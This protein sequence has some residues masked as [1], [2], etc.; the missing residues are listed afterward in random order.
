MAAGAER[1]AAADAAIALAPAGA[2]S[3]FADHEP[4]RPAGLSEGA[5]LRISAS[6]EYPRREDGAAVRAAVAAITGVG[7]ERVECSYYVPP[8]GVCQAELAPGPGDPPVPEG[9]TASGVVS[10]DYT[11]R[12]QV[13]RLRAA[14]AAMAGLRPSEI[15]CEDHPEPP[16]AID[17]GPG[18]AEPAA[19]VAPA[20]EGAPAAG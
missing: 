7:P 10:G 17:P 18:G 11:A 6:G 1:A 3:C 15:L 5:T 8:I 14:L 19:R 9:A 16:V 2:G 4:G 20:A 12:E 13:E